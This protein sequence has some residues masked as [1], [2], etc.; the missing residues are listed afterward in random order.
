MA[1]EPGWYPDPSGRPGQIYWDGQQW[2]PPA[3]PPQKLVPAAL[4]RRWTSLRTRTKIAAVAA[5]VAIP[6]FTV[7]VAI[8]VADS[9]FGSSG[10]APGASSGNASYQKGFQNGAADSASCYSPRVFGGEKSFRACCDAA[11]QIDDVNSF[12]K[13]GRPTLDKQQYI[14]GCLA[15][16][17]QRHEPL[18][19]PPG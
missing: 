1:A 16:Y 6:V 7:W 5:V 8:G 17:A 19:P 3:S 12:D 10:G 13:Y 4:R 18:N 9:I 2:V 11:Y 14:D 15:G